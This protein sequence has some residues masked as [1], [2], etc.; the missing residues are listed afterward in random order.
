MKTTRGFF[1]SFSLF[2]FLGFFVF[3]NHLI[4]DEELPSRAPLAIYLTWEK[5][6]ST[7][8]IAE[9]FT[10]EKNENQEIQYRVEGSEEPWKKP[11]INTSQFPENQPYYIHRADIS[12]LTPNTTYRF[13]IDDC[14]KEHLFSTMPTTLSAPLTFVEGGDVNLSDVRLFDETSHQAALQ[15]PAFVIIGG[16]LACASPN[17]PKK[18]EACDRWLTWFTHWYQ[19][20]QTKEG[21][22][23]PL[24]VTVG[25]HDVKGGGY[26]QT[27]AQ[28]PFFYLFFPNVQNR[29][30]SALRFGDYLSL[31][32][33]DSGHTNHIGG[34]QTR[35]LGQELAK[36]KNILH[37]IAIY[38]VPAYPNVRPY[39]NSHS[40][41]V[42]RHFVP[43]FDT[44]HLHLAFE[45]HDHSY[46]RT[47]PL[48][49][50][51]IDPY[52]VVY[53]GNGPW[54][55]KPRIPK[56]PEFTTYL[57]KC[58]QARQICAVTLS[59]TQR[60][61]TAITYDGKVIDHFSQPV[62]SIIHQQQLQKEIELV[63]HTPP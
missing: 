33:L 4:A 21:R 7:T 26:D 16:D 54:G 62:D 39:R 28:A 59:S 63:N 15:N 5:D 6:P 11:S 32:F 50:D 12:G 47:Y 53:I 42:R 46:K 57:E 24:L 14:P 45:N 13:K 10:N 55:A 22:I 49:S 2:V 3:F 37:R 51:Q 40:S 1:Q 9:W 17:N 60:D 29:G 31:Y 36:D 41:A 43:V 20:M 61:V 48:T 23:I 56:K 8:M 38:H 19:Q 27:P 35:W 52:G 30:Y 34:E 18:N 25:N 58:V 44:Y